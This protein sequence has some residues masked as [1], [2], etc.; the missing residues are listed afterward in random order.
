MILTEKLE[1]HDTLN[2]KL[3]DSDNKLHHDVKVKIDEIVEQFL[4][5]TEAP[6]FVVDVRIVGSQ[7]SYNYT[8]HSDL[9]V[10]II[11]N[12]ELLDASEELLQILYNAVKTKFNNDYQITIRD[13]DVELYVEDIKSTVVSNGVYSV[14]EDR[15][16]KFPEKLTDVPEVDVSAKFENCRS[17]IERVIAQGNAQKIQQTIDE[18]YI[19]RK[20][21][22]DAE[23]EYSEGNQLFK[24]IRN[25]G[26]LDQLKD[27][28]KDARSK[29]LTL[30]HLRLTEA[31]RTDL[32]SKS[33][34]SK[35]GMER[36]KKR[37]KSRVANSVKQ[38]NAI[39]MNK[40]FKQDILTVD[41]QVKGETDNYIVKISFGGILELLHDQVERHGEFNLKSVTRALVTGFNRDDVFI[42]CSCPDAQYRFAYHQTQ[43]KVNSGDPENRP[44]NITNPDDTLGSSCKHVLLVLSNTSWILK[45]ASTIRNYVKYMEKHYEKL[46]ANVIYPAI[47]NKEYEEPVQFD[48]FDD[49]E[50]ASDTDTL[51]TSN[52][53]AKTKTQFKQGNEYRFQRKDFTKDQETIDDIPEEQVDNQDEPDEDIEEV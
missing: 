22:L 1:K 44:S 51:D 13:I 17:F 6:I 26:L 18:L 4:S 7:A 46:Y 33:K 29:E 15:W 16:I 30:E 12:F 50:L 32:L 40:L 9:D 42:H 21:A 14:K 37:V 27:A 38:Y 3:W 39:D 24:D 28:Y 43:N 8:E 35:K 34:R 11:A 48:I 47:Y 36:F 53:Y 52:K 20:D 45:V 31:S 49:D 2:P 10:H 23:G 25:S 5:T 19:I 41:I